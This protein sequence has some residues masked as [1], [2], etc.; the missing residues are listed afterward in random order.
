[1]LEQMIGGEKEDGTDRNIGQ[2]DLSALYPAD[3]G[4]LINE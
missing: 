3:A 4:K 2:F 1:M